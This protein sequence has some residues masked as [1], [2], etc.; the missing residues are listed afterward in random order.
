MT[1]PALAERIEEHLA[2]LQQEIGL[3]KAAEHALPATRTQAVAAETLRNRARR[4]RPRA[5]GARS[6]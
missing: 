3:L 2:E 4:S 5:P 1:I 6:G